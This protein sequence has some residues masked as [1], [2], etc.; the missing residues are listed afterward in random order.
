[1]FT[2]SEL[3]V[4]QQALRQYSGPYYDLNTGLTDKEV[5]FKDDCLKTANALAERFEGILNDYY[6]M[7]HKYLFHEITDHCRK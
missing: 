7:E 1:M 5:A 4:L 6:D 3:N 2:R